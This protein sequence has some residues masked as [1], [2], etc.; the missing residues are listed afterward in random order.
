MSERTLLK[1]VNALKE[2]EAQK[3]A[4]EKQMSDL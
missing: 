4:L 1:K 3:K 2:L